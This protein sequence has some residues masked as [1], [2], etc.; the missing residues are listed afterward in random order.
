MK[1]MKSMGMNKMLGTIKRRATSTI[2][3]LDGI[4]GPQ[5]DSPEAMAFQGVKQFCSGG[6]SSNGQAGDEVLY[7]PTI[8]DAA[9]SSPAAAAEC[10]RLIRKFL[11]R[12]NI[13]RPSLQYNAIM[14]MRILTDNPNVTTFT[15]NF[16]KKFVDTVKDLLKYAKDPSVRTILVETLDSFEYTKSY[17]EGLALIIDMWKKDKAKTY[18]NYGLPSTPQQLTPRTLNAPAFQPVPQDSHFNNSHSGHR[19]SRLPDAVQLAA[20]LE[21]ARTSA[22]LL[23]QVVSNAEPRELLENDLVKEFSG[24][25][26]RA[27]R[28]IQGYMTAENP[29]PD[30][31][32]MESLIDTNEQLQS[33]L[34]IHQ[35]AVL[36]AKK[37]LGITATNSPPQPATPSPDTPLV[38]EAN[39]AWP[40]SSG[41]ASGGGSGSGSGG[42]STQGFSLS[43][44][45]PLP[46]PKDTKGKGS[47][48]PYAEETQD[49]FADPQE[50]AQ[51]G[52]PSL[53]HK[54]SLAG[55]DLMKLN[56]F[57]VDFDKYAPSGS[58]GG[59]GSGSGGQA[60]G[61][62]RETDATDDDDIYDSAPRQKAGEGSRSS[63]R[64]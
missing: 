4:S 23:T 15:R 55:D 46:P 22:K 38:S 29:A 51:V 32:T 58:A 7:L 31:D 2:S 45:A 36:S 47:V 16:D 59:S 19:S 25:C 64:Y 49:P 24:R 42:Q 21:E 26:Q 57:H 14:L 17:D 40:N 1:A 10:A 27:S 33:A 30:N 12:E 62:G 6:S 37:Q 54:A 44:G 52:A 28:S 20:R 53:S 61:K 34:N 60:T 13:A 3:G 9:E 50:D 63:A 56:T 11:S 48:T 5:G 39:K 43:D 41:T 18:K 8:V 35:R